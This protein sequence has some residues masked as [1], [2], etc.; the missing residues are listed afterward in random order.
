MFS[1]N[2]KKSLYLSLLLTLQFF[3]GQSHQAGTLLA[4]KPFDI[5]QILRRVSLSKLKNPSFLNHLLFFIDI[6][7][8]IPHMSSE[9]NPPLS[10]IIVVCKYLR[11]FLGGTFS[12]AA[13]PICCNTEY[14]EETDLFRKVRN[15]PVLISLFRN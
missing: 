13:L 1:L 10:I 2:N 14:W 3:E 15:S 11:R 6:F 5:L 9:T 12:V 4:I 8:T 7:K